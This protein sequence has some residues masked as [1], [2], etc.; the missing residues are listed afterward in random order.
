[1]KSKLFLF[2]S[3]IL[4]ALQL[5]V[6]GCA[7]NEKELDMQKPSSKI[8]SQEISGSKLFENHCIMCH[9]DN[10]KL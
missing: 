10:S 4:F 1:M 8:P 9:Q 6:Y 7:K 2:I 5:V 3:I